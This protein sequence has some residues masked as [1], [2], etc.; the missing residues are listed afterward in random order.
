MEKENHWRKQFAKCKM[1]RMQT[2]SSMTKILASSY[3]LPAWYGHGRY[4]GNKMTDKGYAERM[5]TIPSREDLYSRSKGILEVDVL[6]DRR[7]AIVGL[8]SFGSHIA[9][10]D[11]G[12]VGE[13]DI[14]DFGRIELHNLARHG[15]DQRR[16]QT[17]NRCDRRIYLGQEPLCR[18]P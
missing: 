6:Q 1:T 10:N 13:F 15:I 8:G 14:F 17:E 2:T 16:R 12:R 3:R 11:Q 9:I 5:T 7:V 4:G 18:H